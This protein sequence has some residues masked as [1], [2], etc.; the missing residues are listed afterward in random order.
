MSQQNPP[1]Q[2]QNR[3]QQRGNGQGQPSPIPGNFNFN[4]QAVERGVQD[5]FEGNIYP[6]LGSGLRSYPGA[7]E[8]D[9]LIVDFEKGIVTLP[10][11]IGKI[12]IERIE[13]L[14]EDEDI[15]SIQLFADTA[16]Q[17]K[18]K[19]SDGRVISEVETDP[20]GLITSR[21]I[22]DIARAEV[23]SISGGTALPFRAVSA[24]SD[25]L[26][27]PAEQDLYMTDQVRIGILQTDTA[28]LQTIPFVAGNDEQQIIQQLD[29]DTLLDAINNL[30]Q[31]VIDTQN[32]G[33][34]HYIVENRNQNNE[35]QVQVR[36]FDV[37]AETA[38][39][40]QIANPDI[41][42][43]TALTETIPVPGGETRLLES[44]ISVTGQLIL[45]RPTTG[46]DSV[47]LKVQYRGITGTVR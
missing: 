2:Q 41:H 30:G 36:A 6:F 25:A 32:T 39:D 34:A 31:G 43:S 10:Q 20:L 14:P 11:N 33:Q 3:N 9:P 27:F 24:A 7:P 23:T 26:Q 16:L 45:G 8:G 13:R 19:N 46:G 44:D 4:R 18:F 1:N 38:G 22:R 47:D 5:A 17:I 42:N 40:N 29:Q 15:R 35:A 37:L 12:S 28:Q 21:N